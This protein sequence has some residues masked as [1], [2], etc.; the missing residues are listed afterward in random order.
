MCYNITSAKVN[1]VPAS[2]RW[3]N[4]E[5][6]H[7]VQTSHGGIL[8]RNQLDY[9]VLYSKGLTGTVSSIIP[10]KFHLS[11]GKHENI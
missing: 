11:R 7:F 1:T 4:S 10:R 6:E 2:F 5:N 9:I 8:I 3:H